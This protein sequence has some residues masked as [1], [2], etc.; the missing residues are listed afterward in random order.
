MLAYVFWHWRRPEVAI[1]D[2]EAGIHA[3]QELL[4]RATHRDSEGTT[5]WRVERAPWL[6]EGTGYEDW[7]LLDDT[8]GLDGLNRRAMSDAVRAGHDAVA[9]MSAGGTAGLYQSIHEDLPETGGG[10]ATW[11]TKPEG[12]RYADLHRM[13][14]PHLSRL[15]TRMMVLGPTPEFCLLES[16]GFTVPGGADYHVVH[17]KQVWPATD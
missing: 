5:V 2:Y 14:S 3:F 8:P 11:F 13:L 10:T 1:P 9:R 7:Y 4:K 17:R 16:E 15:W 6:P 12:L